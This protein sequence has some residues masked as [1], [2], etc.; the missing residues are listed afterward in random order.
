MLTNT[1]VTV[2]VRRNGG[3]WILLKGY[4]GGLTLGMVSENI[5]RDG[6]DDGITRYLK[7]GSNGSQSQISV[8]LI[9]SDAGEA[10]IREMC[11]FDDNGLGGVRIDYPQ[12][13]SLAADGLFQGLI[14]NVVD[15]DTYQGFAVSFTQNEVEVR[16]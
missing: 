1:G 7:G 5:V 11:E 10:L 15:P 4:V 6:D 16:T 2:Y 13:L 3:S 14:E 12:G 9:A 8:R